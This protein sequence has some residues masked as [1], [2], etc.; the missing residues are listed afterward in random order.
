M[1]VETMNFFAQ[2][3]AYLVPVAATLVFSVWPKSLSFRCAGPAEKHFKPELWK[4]LR[5]TIM[6]SSRTAHDFKKQKSFTMPSGQFLLPVPVE[7]V[8]IPSLYLGIYLWIYEAML[9][10][11][12][13]IDI[14]LARHLG[15][16]GSQAD[17]ADS[18]LFTEAVQ[19]STKLSQKEK[20]QQQHQEQINLFQELVTYFL[21]HADIR[22][23]CRKT[24]KKTQTEL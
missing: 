5:K 11:L 9:I 4:V 13:G 2:F 1:R 16:S 12:Q 20:Q 14:I 3:L 22:R 24:H 19:F 23:Q 15:A 10:D 8:A 18:H 6:S 7:D 21:G 17:I